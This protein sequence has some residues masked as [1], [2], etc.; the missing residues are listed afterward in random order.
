[1]DEQVE[2]LQ[3]SLDE[4][5]NLTFAPPPMKKSDTRDSI[6]SVDSDVSLSFDRRGSKGEE[7]D[8]S[9]C[10]SG[11]DETDRCPLKLPEKQ[12]NEFTDNININ[13]HS[14]NEKSSH[15]INLKCADATISLT[16][17]ASETE[18]D[19]SITCSDEMAE[20]IA[21]QVEFY[22]SDDNIVKD[23]FLLKHV[24]R[25]KEGYVSLKLI[26]SFKRVKH[27]S[28]DWRIVGAALRAKSTKLEVNELGTKLRRRNPLPQYDQTL[29]S[30]TIVATK[31]P[32]EKLTIESVAELFRQCGEIALI[33]LLKP[34]HSVPAEVRQA[35]AKR[36][37]LMPDEE[38]AVIEFTDS[39]AARTAQTLDL[40]EAK[41]FELQQT[42]TGEKKRKQQ[43][44]GQQQYHQQ[45]SQPTKKGAGARLS[46]AREN[47]YSSSGIPSG[48]ED[49]THPSR[50]KS[51]VYQ[52]RREVR[53]STNYH[54]YPGSP[55]TESWLP[56][57]FSTCSISVPENNP[58]LIRRLSSCSNSG[59]S[60]D[61]GSYSS[62]R[63]SS[64]SS[65]SDNSYS[66][67]LFHPSSHQGHHNLY[68]SFNCWPGQSTTR[69]FSCCTPSS[70]TPSNM[71]FGFEYPNGNGLSYHQN[72][73]RASAECGPFLRRLSTC[74]RDSGCDPGGRR[75]SSC[76][77]GSDSC[78]GFRS[79]SNSGFVL[80]AHLP[81]NVTRL[82]SGPDGTRGFGR[83]NITTGNSTSTTNAI[84]SSCG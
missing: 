20:K 29:P 84:E 35:L 18:V 24:K 8:L 77:S 55:S 37:E 73:R 53:P 64:C 68:P 58:L 14:N 15:D 41:I 63:Y 82:P 28:R 75:L 66:S 25:N 76:S 16:P 5:G 33:R 7:A 32:I 42:S 11:P 36:T 26:S 27:L 13:E 44:S 9:D 69:R 71:G 30:R 57:R 49:D 34:G 67:P 52:G 19:E 12:H 2:I 10:S 50:I 48:S 72:G 61:S 4:V 47:V 79:R 17:P 1:M 38:C 59:F 21:A 74:S 62:R 31:L 83:N 56:R 23:A 65:A 80:M 43:S 78:S 22:F 39:A 51:R 60:S 6:S 40:G 46:A 3:E 54:S 45:Q 70:S 81:E